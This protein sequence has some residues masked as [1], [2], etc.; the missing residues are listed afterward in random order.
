MMPILKTSSQEL[1]HFQINFA[2]M[3]INFALMKLN[4]ALMIYIWHL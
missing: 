4:F 1:N 2:L 3:E